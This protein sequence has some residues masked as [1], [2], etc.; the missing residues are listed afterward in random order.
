M[1]SFRTD[2]GK[3]GA[4]LDQKALDREGVDWETLG[5]RPGTV[6]YTCHLSTLGR[7]GGRISWA[8][9]FKTS[10][11]NLRDPMSVNIFK[12]RK[13][14]QEV[15]WVHCNLSYSGSCRGRADWAQEVETAVNHHHIA[16]FQ[17]GQQGE[18]LSQE[19]SWFFLFIYIGDG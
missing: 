14:S 8:Q 10:L 2:L 9:E 5:S 4:G 11:G 17:P 3:D 18:T 12:W 7:W 13:K 16:A 6:A 15:V 19:Q 1:E